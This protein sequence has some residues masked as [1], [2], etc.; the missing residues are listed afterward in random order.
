MIKVPKIPNNVQIEL[1][2]I[3]NARCI[4][5]PISQMK[6]EKG[7]MDFKLFK[8]IIGDLQSINFKG[9]ILPTS[10]GES[11]LIPNFTD[12]L[13]YIRNKLPESTIILYTNASL[14]NINLSKEIIKENLVDQLIV[15]FDGGTKDSFESVRIGLSFDKVKQNVHDFLKIRNDLGKKGP[16]VKITMVITPENSFTRDKLKEEFSD[17]DDINFSVMFNWGGQHQRSEENNRSTRFS[18][19]NYCRLLYDTIHILQNGDVCL[20]CIDYEGREIVGKI[21]DSSIKDVWMGP[22]LQKRRDLLK[23]RMFSELPLC[24][25]CDIINYDIITQYLI[26]AVPIIGSHFPKF[27][28]NV[29]D[30]YKLV[31]F[32]LDES[33]LNKKEK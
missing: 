31:K 26:K 29:V 3:C 32:K 18:K 16:I 13:R 27:T 6:R 1:C 23:K 24:K 11:L 15:S 8:K 19:N 10:Y 2:N 9:N 25:N 17:V 33:K 4:T 30:L 5:C 22:E 28:R 7:I 20:C 12:Y 14:L 21:Q